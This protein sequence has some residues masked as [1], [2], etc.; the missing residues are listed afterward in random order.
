M[1]SS[2]GSDLSYTLTTYRGWHS[3][4]SERLADTVIVENDSPRRVNVSRPAGSGP[5]IPAA[6]LPAW[7]ASCGPDSC[8]PVPP[9]PRARSLCPRGSPQ[10]D[11]G[12]G[13]R[14]R[15]AQAPVSREPLPPRGSR[16]LLSP[17]GSREPPS[18]RAQGCVSSCA[19]RE[20][21]AGAPSA[22]AASGQVHWAHLDGRPQHRQHRNSFVLE[23]KCECFT[24]KTEHYQ[25]GRLRDLK[26]E[27]LVRTRKAAPGQNGA[28]GGGRQR[29]QA[30]PGAPPGGA[31]PIR[32]RHPP[33]ETPVGGGNSSWAGGGP[34]REGGRQ[35][36]P[37]RPSGLGPRG[38]RGQQTPQNEPG[39]AAGRRRGR[40]AGSYLGS[41]S[42]FSS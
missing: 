13:R 20:P 11:R 2:P 37:E 31:G 25:T 4:H 6:P 36:A 1:K 38:Q 8:A 41:G 14:P 42:Q 39:E 32:R 15:G 27:V 17:R 30:R 28:Q 10:G 9:P 5:G 18:P 29:P 3:E 35:G 12:R 23:Q 16:G 40:Q 34:A 24:R 21:E 19:A 7:D 22:R 26:L 33:R